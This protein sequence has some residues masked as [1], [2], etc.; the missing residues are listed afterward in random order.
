MESFIPPFTLRRIGAAMSVKTVARR[1][2]CF[3]YAET[4]LLEAQAGWL[5]SIP[6][7]ELKIELSYQLFEDACHIDAMRDR[8][9]ELGVFDDELFPANA[10]FVRFCNEVTN[11]D[12][13]IERMVGIYWVLRPALAAAY[14]K[15]IA[16]SDTVAD[17]PTVRLLRRALSDHTEFC[18]W[19]DDLIWLLAERRSDLERAA[20]WRE[21]LL[22]L[23]DAAGGIAGEAEAVGEMSTRHAHEPV[24]FRKDPPRRDSRFRIEPYT[25][26]EG[27]AATDVWDHE[28]FLKYMFM[29][30]EGELEVMEACGQTLFDFPDADWQLRFLLARQLWDEARHAELSL[31]RFIELG[32][33]LDMLPV[34]DTFP[35]YFGPI[36]HDDLT[37]RLVHVNQVVEGWVTDDFAMIVDMCRQMQD[38]RSAALFEQLIADEWLHLKIGADWIPRLT[39]GDTARRTEAIAY[40]METEAALYAELKA[41]ARQTARR[42][43]RQR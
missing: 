13:L 32:G 31:Q 26:Q 3:A 7:P 17:Q 1:L 29:M 36:R 33:R 27:R 10:A 4:R 15:H 35:L 19:G 6:Q 16:L 5:A 2:R 41:A 38:E 11:T 12:D 40:R 37:L 24:R 34:R 14:E 28:S 30:V 22:T 43:L 9:P 23:L 39:A 20:A 18:R 42:R 8:L 21:H 25:R